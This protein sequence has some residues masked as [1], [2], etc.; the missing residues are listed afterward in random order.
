MTTSLG[1]GAHQGIRIWVKNASAATIKKGS[2]VS[3]SSVATNN[4]AATFLDLAEKKDFG[5][6]N[7]KQRIPYISVILSIA[8]STTPGVTA[9]L[10][11]A[12]TDIKAGG[13]GEIT[14]YG[15]C[16]VIADATTAAGLVISFNVDGEAIDAAT[17]SH[18]NPF[19]F[20][21]EAGTANNLMWCFVNF[22]GSATGCSAAG[23]MG[24]AY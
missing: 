3:W 17:A 21:V 8:D 5:S 4:P 16:Q 19:G 10:G 2:V 13:F 7:Q 23:F 11:V 22:I 6:G 9:A 12:E 15:L 20:S 24:K 14:T 18:K 1:G